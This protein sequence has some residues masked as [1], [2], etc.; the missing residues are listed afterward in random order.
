MLSEEHRLSLSLC[1]YCG[2]ENDAA[3]AADGQ[4]SR[5]PKPGDCAICFYCAEPAIYNE[6]MMLA[7]PSADQRSM[8]ISDP[9]V[10]QVIATIMRVREEKKVADGGP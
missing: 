1:P 7:K 8:F 6:D 4:P 2:H 3:T 10:Q 5:Q 9:R